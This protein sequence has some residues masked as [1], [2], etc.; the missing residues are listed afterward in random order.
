MMQSYVRVGKSDESD[1]C[2]GGGG[3]SEGNGVSV[4]GVGGG[5]GRGDSDSD[6]V[7]GATG[8]VVGVGAGA[9]DGHGVSGAGRPGR[10]G[11]RVIAGRRH[12][13]RKGGGGGGAAAGGGGGG[14][15]GGSFGGGGGGGGGATTTFDE[16]TEEF[17][18]R[19]SGTGGGGAVGGG[20]GG[21]GSGFGGGWAKRHKRDSR[22]R[23][24]EEV[25]TDKDRAAAVNLGTR[26]IKAS[27]RMKRRQDRNR[28][29]HIPSTAESPTL[30]ALARHCVNDVS[31]S[32]EFID[33]VRMVT[34]DGTG[35]IEFRLEI[36]LFIIK[37]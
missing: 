17:K 19:K 5:V 2:G 13:R 34:R 11:C 37:H 1:D 28:T 10:K 26:D 6:D 33:K 14:G 9:G 7:A 36:L 27:L 12:G 21:G 23:L 15:G 18:T 8:Y 3:G 29:L 16:L 20:V 35:L 31:V 22:S 25:Y 32:L 24:L 30:L 4:G